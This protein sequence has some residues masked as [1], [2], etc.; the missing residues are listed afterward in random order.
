LQRHDQLIFADDHTTKDLTLQPFCGTLL[1]T[2]TVFDLLGWL[3][4]VTARPLVP[5]NTPMTDFNFYLPLCALFA[6]WCATISHACKQDV[7]TALGSEVPPMVSIAYWTFP[8]KT[9]L[10]RFTATPGSRY[11]LLGATL[12]A[13]VARTQIF[14][15]QRQRYMT[16]IGY[17]SP[18]KNFGKCAESLF[19]IFVKGT[20]APA[21]FK[22]ETVNNAQ[23]VSRNNVPNFMSYCKGFAVM[24]AKMDPL[25]QYSLAEARNALRDPCDISCQQLFSQID[26]GW[27]WTPNFAAASVSGSS[28]LPEM[29][30]GAETGTRRALQTGNTRGPPSSSAAG[31]PSGAATGQIV[32]GKLSLVS[33]CVK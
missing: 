13:A 12:G 32:A 18:G 30:A 10:A 7:D 23:A 25:G 24:P 14:V 29:P 17:R 4:S 19:F 1:D 22:S 33:S 27:S 28:R 16:D 26:K 6:K 9:T 21:N 3:L 31:N 20:V 5:P 11:M 2:F 8:Q 15:P